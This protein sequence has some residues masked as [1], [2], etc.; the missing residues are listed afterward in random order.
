MLTYVTKSITIF[1]TDDINNDSIFDTFG[2]LPSFCV[3]CFLV[4][5][6]VKEVKGDQS[7]MVILFSSIADSGS[8]NPSG[9]DQPPEWVILLSGICMTIFVGYCMQQIVTDILDSFYSDKEM[10]DDKHDSDQVNQFEETGEE[11]GEETV[12]EL[13]QKVLLLKKKMREQEFAEEVLFQIRRL[14]NGGRRPY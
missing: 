6:R 8:N 3:I 5:L 7:L 10:K 13:E 11:M 4:I 12:E 1:S 2:Y 9:N 14:N